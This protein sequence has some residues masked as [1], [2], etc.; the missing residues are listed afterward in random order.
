MVQQQSNYVDCGLFSLAFATSVAYGDNPTKIFFD[1]NSMRPHLLKCIEQGQV[2][3]FPA[4]KDN[5][6]LLRCKSVNLIVQLY[7]VCHHHH[8]QSTAVESMESTIL[9]QTS[10]SFMTVPRS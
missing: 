10:R 7:C 2:A 5:K 8:H 1:G 9:R 6:K 4:P 3:P